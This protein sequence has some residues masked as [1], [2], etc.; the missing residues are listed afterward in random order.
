MSEYAKKLRRNISYNFTPKIVIV[1]SERAKRSINANFL[2]PAELMRPFSTVKEQYYSGIERSVPIQCPYLKF[3]DLEEKPRYRE[4]TFRNDLNYLITKSRPDCE[5]LKKLNV[6]WKS[7]SSI[8]QMLNLHS[9]PTFNTV[10][11]KMMETALA[12]D[13][14]QNLPNATVLL[15][16]VSPEDGDIGNAIN[17]VTS[18]NIKQIEKLFGCK[19]QYLEKSILRMNMILIDGR[20]KEDYSEDQRRDFARQARKLYPKSFTRIVNINSGDGKIDLN[21]IPWSGYCYRKR[22]ITSYEISEFEKIDANSDD[23][24][25]G[26]WL[27]NEDIESLRSFVKDSVKV[28]YLKRLGARFEMMGQECLEKKKTIKRGFFGLFRK[29]EKIIMK[30][31]I[32]VFTEVEQTLKDYADLCFS[33]GLYNIALKEYKYLYDEIKVNFLKFFNNFQKNFLIFQIEKN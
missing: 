14:N 23:L 32:Y 17:E 4:V 8:N 27:S 10:W 3:L 9:W 13:V 24:T 15:T 1:P 6:N 28:F 16:I 19:R 30:N 31:G 22:F 29:E 20:N 21:G 5:L 18:K 33:L 25:R 12:E 11:K 26:L 7:K 2:T